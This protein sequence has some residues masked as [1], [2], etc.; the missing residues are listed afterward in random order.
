MNSAN[1]EWTNLEGADLQGA[2][3]EEKE[4]KGIISDGIF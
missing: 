3:L 4:E 2:S 1:F